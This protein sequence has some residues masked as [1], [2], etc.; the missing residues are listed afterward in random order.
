MRLYGF[1]AAFS[2]RGLIILKKSNMNSNLEWKTFVEN[3][4]ASTGA[5]I[6]SIMNNANE[7][8]VLIHC[9]VGGYYRRFS[10]I[11][12][13]GYDIV[14]GTAQQYFPM[15]GYYSGENYYFCGLVYDSDTKIIKCDALRYAGNNYLSQA[16]MWIFYR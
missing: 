7:M 6:A 10:K 13:P 4:S 15:G 16:N 14:N 2:Y 5:N 12:I 11:F 1:R 3:V 9:L 8:M